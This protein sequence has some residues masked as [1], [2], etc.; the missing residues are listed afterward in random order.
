MGRLFQKYENL[1]LLFCLLIF[2][3]VL[4]SNNAREN[5]KPNLMERAVLAAVTPFQNMVTGTVR[6]AI[7]GYH[8]YFYL[9]DTA[10]YNDE[11]L[12]MFHEQVFKNNQLREELKKHR[13]VD[14]MLGNGALK[15]DSLL[16]AE[17]AAWDATNIART[18]VINRGDEQG[19]R[20]GMVAMTRLGLVGRVVA[21]TANAARVL[22]IT[23][24]RSAVDC[25]V[26]RTRTR[27]VVVGQNRK[28][29][30]VL[31]LPVNADVKAG[32]MLISTGLGG[33]YPAGLPVGRIATL[34]AGSSKL[35][36]KA[37]MVPAAD[38]ER[39]EEVIIT[40]APP[41]IPDELKSEGP[42]KK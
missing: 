41:E 3:A 28:R 37:E 2:A 10:A 13:R 40:T 7:A 30:D 27:C 34:E 8:R 23:D 4:L 31:Y 29:C 35:F 24:A 15:P 18:M 39:L 12:R 42:K 25:Y 16:L 22:L 11:L 1:I 33:I 20:E 32:D 9:V 6:G 17:V 19:V 26:Q 14:E 5:R 36:F 21:V 38:L